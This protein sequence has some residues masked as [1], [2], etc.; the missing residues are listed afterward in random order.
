MKILKNL[1]KIFLLLIVAGF[2]FIVFANYSIKKESDSFIS[3][4]VSELPKVKTAVVLGTNKSLSNG[5][6]NLYFKYRIDAAT[7]LYKSG[8]IESIIVSGDNSVKG[9]NEPEQMKLDLIANGIPAD[10]IYE[11][12]AGFRTL[13]SVVRAKEIFGQNKVI[14]ISQKFHNERAV[15]LA[16]KF[17]I[18][19]FGYNA[20]DVNKYA[21]LKTNLREYLAKAKAYLDIWFN[22]EPKFGGEKI[23]IK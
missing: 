17:G 8:K 2:L 19:A 15:F 9:Y 23:E 7:E 1:I 18:E 11:D 22:V 3:Y 21:G 6:P 5:N 4:S 12:F 13:D 10:K 20:K 14:F 16:Q